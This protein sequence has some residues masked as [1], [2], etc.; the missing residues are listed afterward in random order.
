MKMQPIGTPCEATV[1]DLFD[2]EWKL[3]FLKEPKS[4]EEWRFVQYE[5][6]KI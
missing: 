2:R 4:K 6:N 3:T 1:K 5:D